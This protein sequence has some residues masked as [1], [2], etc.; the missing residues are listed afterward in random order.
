[1]SKSSKIRSPNKNIFVHTYYFIC[2]YD[3]AIYIAFINPMVDQPVIF[4]SGRVSP[5]TRLRRI[6][7][8]N[9]MSYISPEICSIPMQMKYRHQS[10][11]RNV[12]T[13]NEIHSVSPQIICSDSLLVL[14]YRNCHFLRTT[15]TLFLKGHNQYYIIK[16]R[17]CLWRYRTD[18][19]TLLTSKRF[20]VLNI[21]RI[22]CLRLP[23]N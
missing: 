11:L 1:M 8:S 14:F 6:P 12:R 4:E 5:S 13:S 15:S 10:R 20:V 17:Y 16:M 2:Q 22:C 19:V 9:L 3:M 18:I 7:T 21:T 23:T